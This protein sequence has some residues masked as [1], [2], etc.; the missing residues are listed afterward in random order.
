MKEQMELCVAAVAEK[1]LSLAGQA[2]AKQQQHTPSDPDHFCQ[3]TCYA[4]QTNGQE[5]TYAGI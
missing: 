1:R 4:R 5:T 3:N 2:H